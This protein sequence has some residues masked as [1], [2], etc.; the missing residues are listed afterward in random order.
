MT[1]AVRMTAF[2]MLILGVQVVHGEQGNI[3]WLTAPP[4]EYGRPAVTYAPSP[5]GT[6]AL[7]PPPP[8]ATVPVQVGPVVTYR[9]LVPAVPMPAQYFLG[10]GLLGQPKLYV[11]DQPLRNFFRYLS[12]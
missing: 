10:Q 4:T 11:P 8:L 9:P 2:L 7:P 6:L 12:P 1:I 5:Q 3:V